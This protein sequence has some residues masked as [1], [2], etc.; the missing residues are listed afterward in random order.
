MKK[1]DLTILYIGKAYFAQKISG[2]KNF[3]V[4]LIDVLSENISKIIIF[5][6][7]DITTGL[8][9]KQKDNVYI[10]NVPRV[11]H[12]RDKSS[13]FYEKLDGRFS[14]NHV[15]S[16]V[17][18]Q[19]ETFLT[20]FFN[21]RKI[22][23]IIKEHSVDVI[24]FMD[25]VNVS[26]PLIKM[27]SPKTRHIIPAITYHKK[28]KHYDSY[29]KTSM[30]SADYI[31]SYTEA[32]KDKLINLGIKS[33]K[34]FH[35]PWGVNQAQIKTFQNRSKTEIRKSSMKNPEN[36]LFLWSGRIQ[37]I[38]D[39]EFFKALPVVEEIVK[40]IQNVEFMFAFK[41]E[42]Y[43][44]EYSALAKER[45]HIF[46]C[47][48]DFFD[49]LWASDYFFSP[50]HRK[51]VIIAPPLTWI[52]SIALQTPVITTATGGARDVLT[53]KKTGF[54]AN[55]YEELKGLIYKVIEEKPTIDINS[56]YYK[57]F[58]SKYDIKVITEKYLDLYLKLSDSR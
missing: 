14:Y 8:I 58:C 16:F 20:I 3:F 51:E 25:N 43:K 2:D 56:E 7:N 52:E 1:K 19:I 41:P 50:I 6:I 37:N 27:I 38:D 49:L 46:P 21:I 32:Y 18:E 39:Y 28:S 57:V 30:D 40:E 29:I 5:S 17:Q 47:K 42:S 15:H 48:K 44:Y 11:F 12:S 36:L 53:S 34:I 10:Y 24:H 35:I 45:I 4:D 9:S 55:D 23:K 22:K 31:V 54:I 13:F 33:E 26:I